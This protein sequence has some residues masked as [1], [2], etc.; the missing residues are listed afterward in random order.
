MYL[1]TYAFAVGVVKGLELDDVGMADDSHD[2][3]LTILGK[4][5]VRCG[6]ME[7]DG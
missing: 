7:N 6:S 4:V 1:Q 2:L 3:Q 5:S